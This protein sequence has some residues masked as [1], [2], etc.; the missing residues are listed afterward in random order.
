MFPLLLPLFQALLAY[1]YSLYCL[2]PMASCPSQAL[3]PH[4]T[5][6]K[7]NAFV[8]FHVLSPE[9]GGSS[10]QA[11]TIRLFSLQI[12]SSVA[13]IDQELIALDHSFS[14]YANPLQSLHV[15]L[16]VVAIDGGNME[17]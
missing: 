4:S 3:G 17:R 8:T 7:P 1:F 6:P 11:E 16:I 2:L 13:G 12:R 10:S 14:N 5:P 15:T 9:V